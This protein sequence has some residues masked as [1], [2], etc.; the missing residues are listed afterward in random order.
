MQI[1]TPPKFHEKTPRERKR[2]KMGAGDGKK[3]EILGGPAEGGPKA[4]VPKGG[5]P[6]ISRFFSSP[7]TIFILSCETP[8][9]YSKR[10]HLRVPAF[11]HTTKI[12]R[13]D[14]RKN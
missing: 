6:K 3:D 8:A 11:N 1:Q 12:P 2:A 9:A 5:R 7:A 14:R 10:A 4:G 13:Y